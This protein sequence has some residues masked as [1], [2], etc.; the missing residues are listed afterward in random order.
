MHTARCTPQALSTLLNDEALGVRLEA[1]EQL[2][3]LGEKHQLLLVTLRFPMECQLL[4]PLLC[5]YTAAPFAASQSGIR[6][7]NGSNDNIF[8]GARGS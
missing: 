5:S 4:H 1:L 2:Q 3:Q 8:W 6:A 7:R